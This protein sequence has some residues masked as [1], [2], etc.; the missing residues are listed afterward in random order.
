MSEAVQRLGVGDVVVDGDADPDE[1]GEMRV[2]RVTDTPACDYEF[3]AGETVAEDNPDHPA[4]AAVV[5][6]VFEATLDHRVPGWRE[7]PARE[8][9]ERLDD[10]CGDWGV[11]VRAYA[12]PRGRLE[13]AP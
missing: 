3:K 9:R 2:L 5:E 7:W 11:P 8:L 4:D 12:Y 1:R 13:V 10:Y 6:V